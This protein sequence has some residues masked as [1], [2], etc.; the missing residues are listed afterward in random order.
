MR[1][2]SYNLF[3]GAK[4]T[5]LELKAFVHDQAIDV[6]CLQEATGWNEGAPSRLAQFATATGL[7]THIF[8]KSNTRFDLAILSRPPLKSWEVYAEGFCHSAVK[9]TAK[10]GG[11]ELDV[12]NVHLDPRDEDLRLAEAERL[13]DMIDLAKPGLVMGDINSLSSVDQYPSSLPASLALQGITKFGVGSLRFDVTDHFRDHGLTDVAAHR[14]A[15][16]STVPTYANRDPHHAR[17]MR[18]DY[19]FATP[20]AVSMIESFEVVKNALTEGISDHYP[21]VVTLAERISEAHAA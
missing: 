16:K 10:N 13:T 14:G 7:E 2:A 6:L 3:E 15:R 1:I 17:P 21:I 12:W 4:D 9:A 8:S 5:L 19:I 18:L 20:A 11:E